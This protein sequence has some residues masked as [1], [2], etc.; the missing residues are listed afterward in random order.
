MAE[1]EEKVSRKE[2]LTQ[3]VEAEQ[4][5]LEFG[6][7][8]DLNIHPDNRERTR[9]PDGKFVSRETVKSDLQENVFESGGK[10]NN[11]AEP[12]KEPPVWERPPKSWKKEHHEAWTKA[13]PQLRQYYV[14]RENEL[15]ATSAKLGNEL[16]PKAKLAESIEAV[17]QPYMNTI[18]GL[19]VDLPAAVKGLMQ[20]DH[21]LRNLP[22]DQKQAYFIRLGQQYGINLAG[23]G[24]QMQQPQPS[25]P[26]YHALLNQFNSLRGEVVSFK[27]QQEQ[28]QQA[29]ALAHV[30]QFA[31]THEYF[32][33][34]RPT[35]TK[36]IETGMA[37]DLETAYNKALKL[38]D[39][40]SEQ[41]AAAQNAETQRAQKEKADRAAKAAKA[42]AV[43]V[44][45]TSPGS[46]PASK[47]QSRREMLAE[48]LDSVD[49]RL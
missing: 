10:S 27:Q 4:E 42:A 6:P 33:E 34:L 12:A 44:R 14:Q 15:L 11:V 36:L 41:V 18:R 5:E 2:L 45:G 30:N 38:D 37:S 35:I 20:A 43:S 9:A 17:A 47:A 19:G 40:L 1:A 23:N 29:D 3:Q 32:E 13:D 21:N 7:E 46:R 31:S 49:S 8:P 24:G 16:G 48:Q 39:E 28:A 22:P 26:N 25:D